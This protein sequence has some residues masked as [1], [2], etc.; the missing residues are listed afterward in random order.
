MIKNT[1][2]RQFHCYWGAVSSCI[3]SA[4][5]KVPALQTAGDSYWCLDCFL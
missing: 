1:E 4:K 2:L 3:S 5:R